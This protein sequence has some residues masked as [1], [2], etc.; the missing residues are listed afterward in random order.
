[1]DLFVFV[2]KEKEKTQNR[3]VTGSHPLKLLKT[4]RFRSVIIES[5][6]D[7]CRVYLVQIFPMS[8]LLI[9][10]DYYFNSLWLGRNRFA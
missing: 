9:W 4:C 1:M 2:K 8:V 7:N 10:R 3:Q 6:V 5:K